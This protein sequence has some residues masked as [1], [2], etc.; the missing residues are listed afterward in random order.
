MLAGTPSGVRGKHEKRGNYFGRG[1][2][3]SAGVA[4]QSVLQNGEVLQN[5]VR[6]CKTACGFAKRRVVWH[7]VPVLAEYRGNITYAQ[8]CMTGRGWCSGL[9]RW[10]ILSYYPCVRWFDSS[11]NPFSLWVEFFWRSVSHPVLHRMDY[12]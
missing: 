8:V 2:S 1:S 5:S 12:S 9:R 10:L 6:F 3:G 7:T 4:A 11:F